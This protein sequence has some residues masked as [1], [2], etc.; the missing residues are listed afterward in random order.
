MTIS[1]PIYLFFHIHNIPTQT[2]KHVPF[3][4]HGD[5]IC[6]VLDIPLN[7]ATTAHIC[8]VWGHQSVSTGNL[9]WWARLYDSPFP[10]SDPLSQLLDKGRG[11]EIICPI[12]AEVLFGMILCRSSLGNHGYGELRL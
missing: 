9:Q 3:Q 12:W 5:F 11:L 10:S 1:T 7:T 2:L 8:R 6:F 4:Y